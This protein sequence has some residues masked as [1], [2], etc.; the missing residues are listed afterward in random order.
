MN[1]FSEVIVLRHQRSKQNLAKIEV[2]KFVPCY[3]ILR[4]IIYYDLAGLL[5]KKKK[6]NRITYRTYIIV[7]F[8]ELHNCSNSVQMPCEENVAADR[9]KKQKKCGVP[10]SF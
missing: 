3:V 6:K 8:S 4:L 10:T 5:L 2:Q 1:K 7:S 9:K